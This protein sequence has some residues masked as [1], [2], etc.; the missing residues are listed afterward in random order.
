MSLACYFTLLFL[1]FYQTLFI[2]HSLSLT[3]SS[4][5]LWSDWMFATDCK[6]RSGCSRESGLMEV[7][8]MDTVQPSLFFFIE[9]V[10]PLDRPLDRPQ[11]FPIRSAAQLDH[12]DCFS[13]LNVQP[14]TI[15][16]AQAREPNIP[17]LSAS[18]H[19]SG[20]HHSLIRSLHCLLT[21]T[22]TLNIIWSS[23]PSFTVWHIKCLLAWY[24]LRHSLLCCCECC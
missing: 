4:G 15:Q 23:E 19:I 7:L 9:R 24:Q 11:L 6:V 18:D 22:R 1:S 12:T 20:S 10:R 14:D 16:C 5:L 17:E 8:I 13:L 3:V 21:F 2:I